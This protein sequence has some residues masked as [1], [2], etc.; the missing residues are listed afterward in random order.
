MKFFAVDQKPNLKDFLCMSFTVK[1]GMTINFRLMDQ[2]KPY[3]RRLAI[4]L[5]FSQHEIAVM[6]SK[7]DPVYYLLSEWLRGANQENDLRPVTWRTLIIA[8][9]DANVQDEANILE[10]HYVTSAI[11]PPGGEFV[12]LVFNWYNYHYVYIFVLQVLSCDMVP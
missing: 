1:D 6:E 3:W 8:L 4:A 10:K 12:I 9:R 11:S 7:D 5:N 2:V